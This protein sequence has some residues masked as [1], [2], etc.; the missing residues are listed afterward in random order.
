MRI[1]YQITDRVLQLALAL[2][3][4]RIGLTLDDIRKKFRVSLRTAQRMRDAIL[5]NYPQT[6]QFVDEAR[7]PRWRIPSPHNHAPL[8]IS[9]EQLADLESTARY[10]RQRNLHS[11][12]RNLDHI[13]SSIKAA[14]P[15]RLQARLEPDVEALLEAEGLAMRPGP[16]PKI[17]NEVI[18]TI[19]QAIKQSSEITVKYLK[20]RSRRAASRRLQPYGFLL[21]R[22]HYL[23]AKAPD[24][25]PDSARIYAL[26][27]IVSARL[28]ERLFVRDEGFSLD[29]FAENSF[30][31]FQEPA[32]EI[33]WRFKPAV[34]DAVL[35]Y[36][37]HPS[38]TVRKQKDGSVLVSFTAGG[39][40]EMCWHLYTWGTN[41]E[42]IKPAKLRALMRAAIKHNNFDLERP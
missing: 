41:V 3:A 5:R 21:G 39:F 29:K 12:A 20:R 17:A 6:E 36:Q 8:A 35:G 1:R 27:S 33:V 25:H 7:R 26:S 42:V 32:Q 9:A 11:K 31:V 13:A 4:T 2:Q 15:A 19:R 30:G 22:Q 37:F 18:D 10:L 16:K 34:A 24:R 40:V 28:S 23:V 14:L 38:Q